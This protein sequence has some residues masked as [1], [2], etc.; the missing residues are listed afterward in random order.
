MIK[1]IFEKLIFRKTIPTDMR[2]NNA[3]I[4]SIISNNIEAY[5]FFKEKFFCFFK[6]DALINSPDFIGNITLNE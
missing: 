1:K 2:D 4:L 6:Y 5:P 3:P